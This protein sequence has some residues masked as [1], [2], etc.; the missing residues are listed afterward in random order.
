MTTLLLWAFVVSFAVDTVCDAIEK[1]WRRGRRTPPSAAP[2]G[3]GYPSPASSL[4]QSPLWA[5]FHVQW[6]DE[7]SAR[8]MADL[9]Q[10]APRWGKATTPP[11]T[12]TDAEIATQ[13]IAETASYPRRSQA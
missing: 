8:L 1:R 5:R 12:G 10:P 13:L 3:K 2:L 7:A 9:M 6:S 4:P 11:L